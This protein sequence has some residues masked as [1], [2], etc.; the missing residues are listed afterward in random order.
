[1]YIKRSI[2]IYITLTLILTL[3]P[4]LKVGGKVEDCREI[5]QSLRTMIN[6][7]VCIL[8]IKYYLLPVLLQS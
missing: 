3:T 8:F 7:L 4:N 5:E 6:L 2:Y 1:M